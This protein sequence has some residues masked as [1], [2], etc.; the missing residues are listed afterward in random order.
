MYTWLYTALLYVCICT[1]RDIYIDIYTYIHMYT[2]LYTI[3]LY[4]IMHIYRHV[5]IY[6]HVYTWL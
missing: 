3:L 5:Y 4:V 6:I 2:W 1:Y